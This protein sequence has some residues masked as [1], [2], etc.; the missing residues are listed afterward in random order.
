MRQ[1]FCNTFFTPSRAEKKREK[2]KKSQREEEKVIC[3]S[4]KPLKAYGM[5]N[6]AVAPRKYADD[7]EAIVILMSIHLCRNCGWFSLTC[8]CKQ[9]LFWTSHSLKR[10][11]FRVSSSFGEI[12]PPSSDWCLELRFGPAVTIVDCFRLGGN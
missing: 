9:K 10:M 3:Y 12:S 2:K 7:C 5:R 8:V 4:H 11:L 1:R 6:L